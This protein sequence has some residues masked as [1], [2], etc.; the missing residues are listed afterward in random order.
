MSLKKNTASQYV[1]FFFG[2]VTSNMAAK[3]GDA[4]QITAYVSLNGAAESAA[5][6]AVTELD[7]TNCPGVYILQ[8]SQAETNA[9]TV[10]V[11]AESSTANVE[12]HDVH[13]LHTW[14]NA[15]DGIAWTDMMEAIMSVVT[16]V[17]TKRATG[18]DHMKRD[19]TTKKVEID[20]D[21]S[22][23]RTASTIN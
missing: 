4:A 8:L 11:H 18:V 2:T 1:A 14:V 15:Y 12:T 17:T 9:N 21:T 19:G 10:I 5:D 16:G 3:T 20:H 22:G 7:A 6:N 23:N 13:T